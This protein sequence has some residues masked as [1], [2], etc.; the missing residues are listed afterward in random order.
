M[1]RRRHTADPLASGSG[2]TARRLRVAARGGI[3]IHR[4][5]GAPPP[6]QLQ[7]RGLSPSGLG[8]SPTGRDQLAHFRRRPL[9][10]SREPRRHRPSWSRAPGAGV[11]S[12]CGQRSEARRATGPRCCCPAAA[13]PE[14]RPRSASRSEGSLDAQGERRL[15]GSRRRARDLGP[16]DASRHHPRCPAGRQHRWL[17]RG[18]STLFRLRRPSA[19]RVEAL[20]ASCPPRGPAC[21]ELAARGQVDQ[22][23]AAGATRIMRPS[24]SVSRRQVDPA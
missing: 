22:Y 17:P 15:S 21:A 20:Q 8:C 2:S 16:A 11:R 12:A 13:S 19:D 5:D 4:A 6:E 3:L 7:H 9:Q 24:G 23:P 14:S 18:N 10:R 1:L